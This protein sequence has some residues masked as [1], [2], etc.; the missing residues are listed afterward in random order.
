LI[1]EPGKKKAAQKLGGT[2]SGRWL[3]PVATRRNNQNVIVVMEF[4]GGLLPY[5]QAAWS[6]D[7]G[8]D[9][10]LLA[11]GDALRGST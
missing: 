1:G 9:K 4:R 11:S 5:T 3:G 2:V 8:T 6:L 10:S 7:A